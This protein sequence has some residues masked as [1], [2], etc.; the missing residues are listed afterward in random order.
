MVV[1]GYYFL[2][3]CIIAYILLFCA[4]LLEN[5]FTCV[6]KSLIPTT[7]KCHVQDMFYVGMQTVG[8]ELCTK[9]L[10]IPEAHTLV[11]K[12]ILCNFRN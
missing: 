7:A 3:V 1:Y 11:V 5:I 6:H 4:L 9:L 10:Q 8:V 2:S 12:Y